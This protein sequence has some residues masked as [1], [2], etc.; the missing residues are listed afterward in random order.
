LNWIQL[1]FQGSFWAPN[2]RS[3]V[4][5]E[6]LSVLRRSNRTLKRHWRCTHSRIV[7]KDL[8]SIEFPG[9]FL[10]SLCVE[11]KTQ[12]NKTQ[13]KTFIFFPALPELWR[14]I[15]GILTQP[16]TLTISLSLSLFLS[17][18]SLSSL[19]IAPPPHTHTLTLSLSSL[20]LSLFTLYSNTLQ[21]NLTHTLSLFALSSLYI[22]LFLSSLYSY[23]LTHTFSSL[24]QIHL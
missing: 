9:K 5:P 2:S 17:L 8:N 16:H 10:C 20:S 6:V 22:T 13:V 23:D 21:L 4:P 15:E 14:A 11:V 3:K 24:L 19:Y 7:W 12:G 1:N 18:H